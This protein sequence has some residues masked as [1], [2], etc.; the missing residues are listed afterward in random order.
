MNLSSG[1]IEL[2]SAL[3][4][5]RLSWEETKLEWHD[6]V[7]QEFDDNYWTPMEAQV[8]TTLRAIDRLAQV[9]LRAQQDCS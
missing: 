7:R 9:L 3:K 2:N 1:W 4:T 5:L 6:A 8:G